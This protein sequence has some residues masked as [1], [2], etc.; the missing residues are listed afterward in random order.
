M[1]NPA[2]NNQAIILFAHGA[3]DPAW[4]TPM[5]TVREKIRSISPTTKVEVAFLEQMHPTLIECVNRLAGEGFTTLLVFPLFIASGNHLKHD[6]P[7][8]LAELRRQHPTLV[9]KLMTPAGEQE[10]VQDEIARCA[11]QGLSTSD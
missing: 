11:L 10:S 3:R 2:E 7:A 1:K 8:A 6:L 9:F 4:A 5:L